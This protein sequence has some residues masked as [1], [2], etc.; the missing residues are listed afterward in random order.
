MP[1]VS[2]V[3]LQCTHVANSETHYAPIPFAAV[4]KS[5]ASAATSGAGSVASVATSGASS[6][7][8]VASTQISGSA[9]SSSASGS[10][11]TYVHARLHRSV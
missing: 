3:F 8:S 9:S 7:A 1:L 4:G 10:A 2:L 11:S 5:A 6:V